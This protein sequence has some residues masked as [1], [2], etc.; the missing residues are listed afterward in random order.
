MPTSTGHTQTL[1]HLTALVIRAAA[2][3]AGFVGLVAMIG[4]LGDWPSL[5][6]VL[7]GA[8]E[9]KAN[10]ALGLMAAASGLW[11]LDIQR[12]PACEQAGQAMS[13]VVA[14]LGLATLSQYMF[15]WE[16]GIDELL[17]ED[18]GGAF[19]AI[20]GRMS[21]YTA[22]SFAALGLALLMLPSPR[23]RTLAS[24]AAS[25][26]ML[27]G[28]ISVV[29][30]AWNATELTT[31]VLLPPVAI[32]TAVALVLLSAG[33]M[34]AIR[35]RTALSTAAF[36]MTSI[37]GKVLTGFSISF[38][39][40]AIGFGI[41]YKATVVFASSAKAVAHTQEVRAV[42]GHLHGDMSEAGLTQ[43][44]YLISGQPE[45][46]DRYR[47]LISKVADQVKEV[48]SLVSDNAPQLEAVTNLQTLM[49]RAAALLDRGVSLYQ[50]TGF[51]E[52]KKLVDSGQGL[53]A[54]RAVLVQ[55][56]NI[57][58]A[59][60]KL[61]LERQAASDRFASFT[62][63]SM[64]LTMIAAACI[65]AALYRQIR[66]EIR[67]RHLADQ[68]LVA[69]RDAA[70]LSRREADAANHAKSTF[71]ATM[72][73]EIRTPM[74]GVLGML[75]LLSLTALD[76]SQHATLKIIRDSG[77]SL[78]RIIDD[79]LDFSKMEADKLSVHAEVVSL[80]ELMKDF[81]DI[82]AVAASSKG[83]LITSHFDPAISP[84]VQVDPLRLRQILSNLVSNAIKFTPRGE[85]RISADIVDRKNGEERI[86][87]SV[88][89]TGI[90]I[91]E[92][93]QQLLFQPFA[94]ADLSITRR[95]GGTGLGLAI[96]QRLASLMGGSI[97]MFSQPG[98]GTTMVLELSLPIADPASL[99][100]AESGANQRN[101]FTDAATRRKAP[102]TSVAEAEGTLVLL[103]DDHPTNRSLLTR[104]LN[105]LGYASESA[106]NGVEALGLWNSGRFSLI[107]TDCNMP[108]MDGYE[109][110]R[111]VR[112]LE[113]VR[114]STRCPIVA[115]T[116]NALGGEA[117]VCQE[118][119]MDDYLVKPV[120]L[121]QLQGKLDRWLPLPL[122]TI[123]A[124]AGGVDATAVT[125]GSFL[126]ASPTPLPIDHA[127]LARM[128]EGD[129]KLEREIFLEFQRAN[130]EDTRL[131]RQA[132]TAGCYEEVARVAHLIKGAAAMV[133]AVRL[134]NLCE[135]IERA[136][137]AKNAEAVAR[138]T[139][140]LEQ[141][142]KV[143]DNYFAGFIGQVVTP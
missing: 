65:F 4:W 13:V 45:Q 138:D 50:T 115:C 68:A 85:V 44:N 47:N 93:H 29:G 135:N 99:V 132:V 53:N 130:Q 83:V 15:G 26:P 118:A 134:A 74:N 143:L 111:T 41:S 40:L 31:D 110:A 89:D 20:P 139:K 5:K 96:C 72:S 19:N 77:K 55:I 106:N 60:G 16:M 98:V 75:E 27:V 137:Q 107:L 133:G 64:L 103:V 108:E 100:P 120:E 142:V 109:L 76:K 24:I 7:P 8:V 22:G 25:V 17:F 82:Y 3:L 88:K 10:T 92:E 6:S 114:G 49:E 33:T 84:A 140:E 86:R 87:F 97:Q 28:V 57:E 90:G 51:V 78:V 48:R 129:A 127:A 141:E 43:R 112:R 2:A 119:G 113:A 23:M 104:Q 131:L 117:E 102:E 73:H 21:P 80:Q 9:M 136:A 46:L 69:A 71:L 66:L 70:E 36:V 52:A 14:A 39:L 62:A 94:Q 79:I 1:L 91:S 61:L 63:V 128:S 105:L 124:I 30:Y 34:L 32:N 81:H 11:L 56:E 101:T 35:R 67:A 126:S 38:L 42:L 95:Y 122:P 125:A 54:V 116:A 37:E 12:S 59:E 58:I 18:T 123:A 121:K